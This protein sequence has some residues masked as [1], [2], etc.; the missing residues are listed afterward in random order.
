MKLF[1]MC[2]GVGGRKAAPARPVHQQGLCWCPAMARG[3]GW[4]R[5]EATTWDPAVG[6]RSPEPVRG[7]TPGGH[8]AEYWRDWVIHSSLQDF[9]VWLPNYQIFA[10][11]CWLVCPYLH[12]AEVGPLFWRGG[13][14]WFLP[15][16]SLLSAHFRLFFF[17][18]S[19]LKNGPEVFSVSVCIL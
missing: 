15:S 17:F 12:P 1:C 9:H 6:C 4:Q 19:F 13:N 11:L 5:E 16:W 10:A 14:S 2:G 7:H 18:F 3:C 8:V